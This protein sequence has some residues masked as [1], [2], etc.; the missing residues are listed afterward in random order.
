MLCRERR[1][2][3]VLRNFDIWRVVRVRELI[4]EI[5]KEWFVRLEEVLESVEF[6]KYI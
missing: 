1:E 6:W 2:G 3:K 4:K 5:E